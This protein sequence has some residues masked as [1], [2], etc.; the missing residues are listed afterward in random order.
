MAYFILVK[1]I[2]K[3]LETRADIFIIR[4][5]ANKNR[6]TT[7]LPMMKMIEWTWEIR[8]V[9]KYWLL[10]KPVGDPEARLD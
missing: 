7:P 1:Q 8:E 10:L 2:K 6:I 9:P 4:D 5:S 3:H